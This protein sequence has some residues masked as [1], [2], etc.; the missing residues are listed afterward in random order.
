[1]TNLGNAREMMGRLGGDTHDGPP[2]SV[3]GPPSRTTQTQQHA[4]GVREPVDDLSVDTD[5]MRNQRSVSVDSGLQQRAAAA[6][7]GKKKKVMYLDG[8]EAPIFEGESEDHVAESPIRSSRRAK[9]VAM[10]VDLGG[11]EDGDGAAA[12]GKAKKTTKSTSRLRGRAAI[13]I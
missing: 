9:T 11:G 10:E 2:S 13:H 1:M 5:G 12:T 4:S 6:A 7:T 8:M 3:R